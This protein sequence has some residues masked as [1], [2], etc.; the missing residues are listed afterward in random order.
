M[1]TITL[2]NSNNL[3][4]P[5]SLGVAPTERL[6]G[7]PELTIGEATSYA[8]NDFLAGYRG[9]INDIRSGN[10][11]D[12]RVSR[13]DVVTNGSSTSHEVRFEHTSLDKSFGLVGSLNQ[14]TAN[15]S[16]FT[17]SGSSLLLKGPDGDVEV[18]LASNW[19]IEFEQD[20]SARTY[21]ARDG[22]ALK[23]IGALPSGSVLTSIGSGSLSDS[24][25]PLFKVNQI[26]GETYNQTWL[27]L[28]G[29]INYTLPTSNGGEGF[30]G[31]LT[32]AMRF[33]L[34]E[35]DSGLSVHNYK[36]NKAD[37]RTEAV[38]SFYFTN[39]LGI[40]TDVGASYELTSQ[41]WSSGPVERD[42]ATLQPRL[43][44]GAV[45]T[46]TVN[47]GTLS[48]LDRFFDA[49][50]VAYSGNDTF[51]AQSANTDLFINAGSGNDT[52]NAGAGND[53][54][55]GG[56]GADILNGGAGNDTFHVNQFD[57]STSTTVV[58]YKVETPTVG[59]V[60][61][62]VLVATLANST[63]NGGAGIDALALWTD[64]GL[65]LGQGQSEYFGTGLSPITRELFEQRPLGSNGAPPNPSGSSFT[66]NDPT[67]WWRKGEPFSVSFSDVSSS[68][69]ELTQQVINKAGIAALEFKDKDNNSNVRVKFVDL[70]TNRDLGTLDGHKLVKTW[71][72]EN[73][74][75]TLRSGPGQTE[76]FEH[77]VQN[78]PL[79]WSNAPVDYSMAFGVFVATSPYLNLNDASL[80]QS[81]WV[82]DS[83]R[84]NGVDTLVYND[85]NSAYLGTSGP[86]VINLSDLL[87]PYQTDV[88][89]VDHVFHGS[90]NGVTGLYLKAHTVGANSPGNQFS[91][92]MADGDFTEHYFFISDPGSGP[93][94][95]GQ[96]VV[97]PVEYKTF[98]HQVDA[99]RSPDGTLYRADGL[100]VALDLVPFAEGRD[101]DL[102]GVVALPS[103]GDPASAQTLIR[104][105]IEGDPGKFGYE[106]WV[107]LNSDGS[108]A[109]IR[110]FGAVGEF[111]GLAFRSINDEPSREDV[112]SG[113]LYV[114]EIKAT[115]NQDSKGVQTAVFS[116][117]I[118]APALAI[119]RIALSDIEDFIA[120]G[121]ESLLEKFGEYSK[122]DLGISSSTASIPF[123]QAFFDVGTIE[124][125]D[126]AVIAV[127][128]SLGGGEAAG[129]THFKVV[130][131]LGD[132]TTEN[133]LSLPGSLA[134]Y[135]LKKVSPDGRSELFISIA[136]RQI[137]RDDNYEHAYYKFTP[138]SS[139]EGVVPPNLS[140]ILPADYY[141]GQN[142]SSAFGQTE[143]YKSGSAL[144]WKD[145]DA[146]NASNYST[147]TAPTPGSIA[148]AFNNAFDTSVELYH[149]KDVEYL[150]LGVNSVTGFDSLDIRPL[151]VASGGADTL[152]AFSSREHFE[153][154]DDLFTQSKVVGSDFSE[155]G[156]GFSFFRSN[157]NVWQRPSDGQYEWRYFLDG[158]AG[159]DTLYGRDNPDVEFMHHRVK[160]DERFE[161]GFQFNFGDS[162]ISISKIADQ[163]WNSF[164]RDVVLK[165]NQLGLGVTAQRGVNDREILLWTN[166]Y[167]QSGLHPS[168][169]Q[170]PLVT[171]DNVLTLDRGR[172]ILN[173]GAGADVMYG[174]G[175]TDL[176]YIDNAQDRPVESSFDLRL[177][178]AY[179]NISYVLEGSTAV[180]RLMVHQ[181]LPNQS[182]NL[183]SE[184]RLTAPANNAQTVNL[185]GNNF[186]FELVGHGGA[187]TIKAGAL[188]GFSKAAIHQGTEWA[189][190][191]PNAG[192]LMLG[193]GGADI[194]EG[195]DRNDHLFGGTGNDTLRGGAG[196]DRFYFGFSQ[197]GEDQEL[198]AQVLPQDY[199][200]WNNF[201]SSIFSE[202]SGGHDTASGGSGFDTVVVAP[203]WISRGY[204]I[205]RM[206]ET[207]YRLSTPH[208]SIT[209][210]SQVE[211]V[212]SFSVIQSQVNGRYVYPSGTEIT[213]H[214]SYPAGST[215][216]YWEYPS[217]DLS[218]NGT[219][220]LFGKDN[221]LKDRPEFY[222]Q[223]VF[224]ERDLDSDGWIIRSAETSH[225]LMRIPHPFLDPA[226]AVDFF[227]RGAPRD[228][229]HWEPGGIVGEG[230]DDYADMQENGELIYTSVGA[231]GIGEYQDYPNDYFHRSVSF[232]NLLDGRWEVRLQTSQDLIG[233]VHSDS[234]SEA[235]VQA[236]FSGLRF[237]I[238]SSH[239]PGENSGE[240]VSDISLLPWASS[241]SAESRD[242]LHYEIYS[243]DP[244]KYAF[245]PASGFS[246]LVILDSAGPLYRESFSSTFDGGAGNDIIYGDNYG[247]FWVLQGGAGDDFVFNG[248]NRMGLGNRSP[249]ELRGDA[250]NDTL[251]Y[252]TRIT[253]IAPTAPSVL[254]DGGLGN[255]HFR[256]IIDQAQAPAESI[257]IEDSGGRDRL[258]IFVQG[259]DIDFDPV[260]DAGELRIFGSDNEMSGNPRPFL[261]ASTGTLEEFYIH[262]FWS[263]DWYKSPTMWGGALVNPNAVAYSTGRMSGGA[264]DDVLLPILG[265]VLNYDG[266]AGNDL[267]VLNDVSGGVVSGGQGNNVIFML[268]S[269]LDARYTISYAWAAGTS[270]G[271]IDLS[272]GYSYV[273][274]KSNGQLLGVDRW[275]NGTITDVI[276]G[277][278]DERIFGSDV[279]NRIDGG[280]G[281]DIIYS[282]RNTERLSA[283][284][285]DFDYLIGG[286]GNDI[287]ID[288]SHWLSNG[289]SG[290]W[291][292]GEYS[293]YLQT[294]KGALLEGGAGDDTYVIQHNGVLPGYIE[295]V[296]RSVTPTRIVERNA[297]GTDAGGR[298][299]L[300][301]LSSEGGA[302]VLAFS[303]VGTRVRVSVQEGAYS[304]GDLVVVSFIGPGSTANSND[305]AYVIDRIEQIEGQWIA[306]FAVDRAATTSGTLRID[307]AGIHAYIDWADSNT[308]AIFSTGDIWT[309]VLTQI[310]SGALPTILDYDGSSV[311]SPLP[312]Q[313]LV[314]RNAMDFV[315]FGSADAESAGFKLPISFGS[316]KVS[317]TEVVL[318]NGP[319][320]AFLYGGLGTD[321]II[322][323]PYDDVLIGGAG[324]DVLSSTMGFD[325]VDGGAGND[326]ILFRSNKQLII[327]GSGADQFAISGWNGDRGAL[328][329]DFKPWEGD[330]IGL[331]HEWLEEFMTGQNRFDSLPSGVWYDGVQLNVN[332]DD[333]RNWTT[334]REYGEF[335]LTMTFSYSYQINNNT[336]TGSDT[337]DL[338]RIRYNSDLDRGFDQEEAAR[339]QV[340][341]SLDSFMSHYY[342]EVYT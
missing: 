15:P 176:Y 42:L 337:F 43:P 17:L 340:Q 45:A 315:E 329:A 200:I 211:A 236:L 72:P 282:G 138:R 284:D 145:G 338:I 263:N 5:I 212:E 149:L 37:F 324:N 35:I 193:M 41:Q 172:D 3:A 233:Y 66:V 168:I 137:D 308:L 60:K 89:W 59:G 8:L 272:N 81:A 316:G 203:S 178:V 147:F 288:E 34:T 44:A 175:G 75:Y 71:V 251:T 217:R 157:F 267:I 99:V 290:E 283:N 262:S 20:D 301:M 297:N 131:G 166:T 309:D 62:N 254:L 51:N 55:S 216:Q 152:Y 33:D 70:Y 115:I 58:S 52:V 110:D 162:S 53:I 252:D 256:V 27:L 253:N 78:N 49:G 304:V 265:V 106:R 229:I 249:Y 276:G 298:D 93:G 104:L 14:N 239:V 120:N 331:D 303:Q 266:G 28:G 183:F 227:R 194:L 143:Y 87:S 241:L 141:S 32:S 279:A 196:D 206:S 163:S 307:H 158:G 245:A 61:Q 294:V 10:L 320:N 96:P 23:T 271:F 128:D 325:I 332:F 187:N 127:G 31:S 2:T 13:A 209:V 215:K 322:D 243:G 286:A 299:T 82:S 144:G 197:N 180:E 287:L 285:I 202:L 333:H 177:D 77:R 6:L 105:E 275:E 76:V 240:L 201:G 174:L 232:R 160:F 214:Y 91:R 102:R 226:S 40:F 268:D 204:F 122:R 270:E 173:G 225:P 181:V 108:T 140:L 132:N 114:Q 103:Q 264:T 244:P 22:G 150:D 29:N 85:S 56:K 306:E 218:V 292:G 107:L 321:L 92:P 156:D 97:V 38:N 219:Y 121:S 295:G 255:D 159:N 188:A 224:A 74:F 184:N 260:W 213:E 95:S 318:S 88:E 164:N 24:K 154:L 167:S 238:I 98:W 313:A 190:D 230:F 171:L 16:K 277:A 36:L 25:N 210:D 139:T 39:G 109:A 234:S 192:A 126:G 302:D 133:L 269:E 327:G 222:A 153:L 191:D 314:D 113:Y 146:G 170:N 278:G 12:W 186:T 1:A 228:D 273:V 185:T 136:D 250:G 134:D 155:M 341:E 117:G 195:G 65:P 257:R 83:V 289:W 339:A 311:I 231:G 112:S 247:A 47:G 7:T 90:L 300:R 123:V 68:N 261:T 148:I 280:A 246:D 281:N 342:Q 64:S 151:Y 84:F 18:K 116:N 124:G 142:F 235:V 189:S 161:G 182:G 221:S 11:S 323:T 101:F 79:S 63:I 165:I 73:E 135:Q 274:N 328:I 129:T 119:Y 67:L 310:E 248:A 330:R 237:T 80:P 111:P 258:T 50:E 259:S 48:F 30:S 312:I 125:I 57:G 334:G 317:T 326:L 69:Y 86:N 179:T 26:G 335:N 198:L 291:R 199:T 46:A 223:N 4:S 205:E 296:S 242:K 319:G 9:F 208:E 169:S 21:E 19:A 220:K 293:S 336:L 94:V 54:I 207:T 305:N 130:D 100:A 118:D